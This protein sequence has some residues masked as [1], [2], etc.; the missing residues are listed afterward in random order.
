MPLNSQTLYSPATDSLLSS[1][2][3]WLLRSGGG[4]LLGALATVLLLS[5]FIRYPEIASGTV[6]LYNNVGNVAFTSPVN[7]RIALVGIQPGDR[8][9][10]NDTLLILESSADF[11]SMLIFDK[12]VSSINTQD[13]ATWRKD[14]SKFRDI[15]AVTGLGFLQSDALSFVKK[16]GEYHLF[17]EQNAYLKKKMALEN[18]I[19]H[20]SELVEIL[21][22]Q[23][24]L[25]IA[26][27]GINSH[28]HTTDSLLALAGAISKKDALQAK[29]VLLSKKSAFEQSRAAKIN[30]QLQIAQTQRSL[31]ELDI[32]YNEQV[33]RLLTDLKSALLDLR[34]KTE[35]WKTHHL[36][37]A[38]FSCQVSMPKPKVV[39]EQLKAG[40]TVLTFIPSEENVYAIAQIDGRSVGK[41]TIGQS[42]KVKL[43][44][45]PHARCG[46][47][48][49]QVKNI[50][51]QAKDNKYAVFLR[52]TQGLKTDSKQYLPFR[53]DMQGAVEIITEERTLIEKF[54]EQ[55]IVL[56]KKTQ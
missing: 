21:E 40:E 24:E 52:F 37:L 17:C 53:P 10:K 49:A 48:M 54:F 30:G 25:Q 35:E 18:E 14:K 12:L 56:V 16:I 2:P 34:K 31:S 45:F 11:R 6:V 42:A 8:V 36:V 39:F 3:S 27:L 41:L 19:I 26:E 20:R 44:A 9:Q 50:D 46:S 28:H 38:P 32:Q 43:E 15:A 29:S 47:L 51:M 22:R 7:A 23:M 1:P 5:F 33:F 55:I 4:V 13:T